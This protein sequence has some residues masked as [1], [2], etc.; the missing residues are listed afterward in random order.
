MG[1]ETNFLQLDASFIP[2]L[3]TEGLNWWNPDDRT[4]NIATGLG[5]V[6][7]VGQEEYTKV[8]NNT[9]AELLNGK[10]C[11]P[12]G[13]VSAQG[14]PHIDYVS[15]D[16]DSFANVGTLVVLTQ[17]IA[18]G[19]WGFGTL[20]GYVRGIDTSDTSIGLIYLSPDVSG[21]VT[22]TIPEFPDYLVRIGGILVSD[23]SYGVMIVSLRGSVGDTFQN[24]WN[25]V[26]REPFIF[27]VSTDG[28]TVSGYLS[29]SDGNP[30]MTMMFSSGFS[31]LITDPDASINLTVGTDD[32]PQDNFIYIPQSTKVLTTSISDWPTLEH[33][34]VG[35]VAIRTAA[36][37]L[38]DGALK[39]H[40]WNDPLQNTV[41]K[42]GHLS[43]IT[44]KL[45][46]FEAQWDTG[47][48]ASVT[49]DTIPTPDN[50]WVTN[51]SG[52]V[53]QMHKHT[54]PAMDTSTGSDLHIVNNFT[55][56]YETI[57][58][59]NTQLSD[60]LGNTLNN[61]SFSFVLWGVCNSQGIDH[62]MIN[63]PVGSYAF[64][65]PSNAVNDANNY[66]VY[67]IPKEF[68][69]T[70]FLMARFTFTYKND[71]WVLYDTED[72]RGKIPN[73]TAGG[74]GGGSGVT[75]FLGLSDTPSAYTG[76]AGK[77]PIV[78]IGE[79]G[80]EFAAT[81]DVFKVGTPANNQI[82]VWTQ[83]SS[84]EGNSSF[85]YQSGVFIV[86]NSTTGSKLINAG[87]LSLTLSSTERTLLN[88]GVTD[89]GVAIAYDFDTS[90][91]L[92][93][94]GAK[95]MSVQNAAVE[96]LSIDKDGNVNITSG[97]EYKIDGTAIGG[98]DGIK[99]EKAEILY[100]NTSQ[101]IIIDLPA[102]AVL[103]DAMVHVVTGFDDSVGNTIDIGITGTPDKYL[104]LIQEDASTPGIYSTLSNGLD[105]MTGDTSI[106]FLYTSANSDATQGQAFVYIKYS[107]H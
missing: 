74:G 5:P 73:T 65:A 16:P 53:Y 47:C 57:Q 41:T 96:K 49:V 1:L 42:Q 77:T 44:E 24:F 34:K 98:S 12:T 51:T 93:T 89:S 79:T 58:N 84:I 19:E 46:Q 103:W 29:P 31:T 10:V 62:L 59:L 67:T 63:L 64:A 37:T 2:S 94:A 13:S 90:I 107:L 9:G 68:Q 100:S 101:S 40:N 27:D 52:V 15:S 21:N 78:N 18:H 3:E 17:N 95:L 97:A 4:I 8:F 56:P 32:I 20:R 82:A 50:V 36:T 6:L 83:D 81:G 102:D 92:T 11:S 33:I 48:E 25:G 85:T 69:G 99:V 105:V 22:S 70:G 91:D 88:P 28:T 87:A 55:T 75:S 14:I 60:A 23:A 61:T 72:L 30:N 39:N 71:D 76:E 80:L 66:S 54:F 106:T 43:H 86:G 35:T 104:D 7:Q 45:R 38:S 26:F